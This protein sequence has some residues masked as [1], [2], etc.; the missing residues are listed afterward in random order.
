MGKKKKKQQHRK[1]EESKP[2]DG[3]RSATGAEKAPDPDK[4]QQAG[5]AVQ[6][7]TEPTREMPRREPAKAPEPHK[8]QQ[9]CWGTPQ[10]RPESM[11]AI[12]KHDPTKMPPEQAKPSMASEE[13]LTMK[14]RPMEVVTPKHTQEDKPGMQASVTAARES[15]S[16]DL[17]GGSLQSLGL[18]LIQAA[19]ATA[20]SFPKRPGVGKVGRRIVLRANHFALKIPDSYLQHYDFAFA[21]EKLPKRLKRNI[22]SQVVKDAKHVFGNSHPVFDG[23]CNM[24]TTRELP[25]GRERMELTLDY[26]DEERQK[27]REFKVSIKWAAQVSLVNLKNMVEGKTN[28]VPYDAIQ[29][30]DVVMRQLPSMR[31]TPVGRSYF[32]PPSS[33]DNNSLGGGRDVWFGFYQSVRPSQWKMMLNIDVSATAFYKSQTVLEFMEEVLSTR[34]DRYNPS[35]PMDVYKKSMF[36]KEIT[37]L[38][39]EV[40]HMG[41][42]KRKYRVIGLTRNPAATEKFPLEVAPGKTEQCTV[43]KYFKDTYKCV[44]KYPNLPCLHVGN[45]ARNTYLPIEVC[46]IVAGQKCNKKLT[47]EQTT[48]MIRAT[49]RPAPERERQI[50]DWVRKMDFNSN[51]YVQEFGISVNYKMTDVEGRVLPPPAIQYKNE[52][53]GKPARGAWN[54]I[55]KQFHTGMEIKSWAL[56]SFAD[57]RNCSMQEL[58]QFAGKLQNMIKTTGMPICANPVALTMERADVM[59]IEGIFKR[60][61]AANPNLQLIVVVLGFRAA[62]IY[63]EVKRVGDVVM[64]LATQCIQQKNA[65]KKMD[66]TLVN[67]CMKINAK[68][69]GVNNILP[70]EARLLIF[71]KPV[72]VFGADVTHPSPGDTHRPSVAAVVASMDPYPSRYAAD[73]RVQKHRQEI[74]AEL[75]VMVKNLLI[76]FYKANRQ[77]KPERIIFYRDG[78][79]EGQFMQV[80]QYELMAIR[81]TCQSLGADYKPAITFVIVQKRH[82]TRLFCSDKRDMEGKAN[83]IPAGVTVDTTIV[84]PTDFD[85]YLCSH[86]GIQVTIRPLYYPV[87]HNNFTLTTSRN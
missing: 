62:S 36:K 7:E 86:F 61:H 50:N 40:T 32:S 28:I 21:V 64:G 6:L 82:H 1:D 72:I 65:V 22:F 63:A 10:H 74:I 18:E 38:K 43:S 24:Y 77:M 37:G 25:I 15:A 46:N 87:G 47:E 44:L 31:Y 58:W 19:K 41:H 13:R 39:V 35:R 12:P 68:M 45:P 3:A 8:Q 79:S 80:L 57:E 66:Q 67:L 17:A 59:S 78:V 33:N 69:G 49:A 2:E 73:V 20:L 70:R 5:A 75:S 84:H 48:N 71:K 56:V 30:L 4:Q 16:E 29:A 54:M 14:T 42:I 55:Q 9:T 52:E 27:S 83:N 26:Y 23:A 34:N 51:P 76:K 11:G 81:A 60:L 53:I 85:F